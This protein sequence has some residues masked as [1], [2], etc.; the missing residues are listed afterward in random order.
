MKIVVLAGSPRQHGESYK[1][2]NAFREGAKK[3]DITVVP[4]GNMKIN[5][6]IGCEYCHTRG[7]GTCIQKDDMLKVNQAMKDAEVV[8]IVSP[9]YLYGLSGQLQ[10]CLSRWYGT[11]PAPGTKYLLMLTSGNESAFAAIELQMWH[12][13]AY[14][15]GSLI[16]IIET[17][18][19]RGNIDEA[20]SQA[21]Y[22]GQNL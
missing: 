19:E 5:G 7:Q 10:S 15:N 21:Y 13:I 1:L 3:H 6:C 18:M 4:V 11:T 22:I 8:V 17:S 12:A 16:S 20:C 14:I 2:I 9:V